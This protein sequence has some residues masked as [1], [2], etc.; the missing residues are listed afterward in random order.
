MGP[1]K[2]SERYFYLNPV[3]AETNKTEIN[4]TSS[5][6]QTISVDDA[7]ELQGD[8][9]PNKEELV[10]DEDESSDE[11]EKKLGLRKA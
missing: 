5:A 9:S 6:L 2:Q 7:E 4:A 1:G 11:G 8:E 3:P 10:P